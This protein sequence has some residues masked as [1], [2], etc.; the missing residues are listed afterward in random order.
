MRSFSRPWGLRR[1]QIFVPNVKNVGLFSACSFGT[2]TRLSPKGVKPCPWS[3]FRPA[4]ENEDED[5]LLAA[6]QR[7][8]IWS[9]RFGVSCRP[10]SND[11]FD[12]PG[13]SRGLIP[14]VTAQLETWNS[15]PGTPL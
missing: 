2:K 13:R 1:W 4:P 11:F 10:E 7:C 12:P 14:S 3:F 15:K 5:D 9:L 6:W 8:E